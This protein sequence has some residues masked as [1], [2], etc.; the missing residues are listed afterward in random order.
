MTIE[1]ESLALHEK[2]KGKLEIKS[3]MPIDSMKMLSLFYTPGVAEVSREIF[4]N[5]NRVYD[6]TNKGNSVAIITDGTRVLGLG[7]IGPEAALPVMEGKAILFKQ[8]GNVDAFPLCIKAKTADEIV[9]F[10]EMVSPTFGG[11][12]IEDIETPKCF[13]IYERL[14]EKLDI[15]VFHDDRHGTAIVVLAGLINALKVVGKKHESAKVVIGGAGAAGLGIAELLVEYGFKNI[16][17]VDSSGIIYEGRKENMNKYKE[18]IAGMTNK[19]KTKGKIEDALAGADVLIGAIGIENSISEEMVRRMNKNQIVFALT[20]P[21]PE[22][23]PDA[24][25]KA[26]A[27]VIGTGR[28]DF[29]NQINNSLAFPGVFRGALDV[30]ARKINTKMQI[31]AAQ[32]LA[33]MVQNHIAEK[34]LPNT[35]DGGVMQVVAKA[36]AS[37]ARES[38]VARL[39]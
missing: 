9:S 12:N 31:A 22:I 32:A 19:N 25:K 3:K 28:S 4:K 13:E 37:A 33:G 16:I 24:A 14:S 39:I 27:K 29:P 26:G 5:K 20:N 15:F 23:Y 34:I 11:I 36:V 18:K 1:S 17:L 30:R 21:N 8:F 38:G 7:K 10:A 35:I 6:L 2:L